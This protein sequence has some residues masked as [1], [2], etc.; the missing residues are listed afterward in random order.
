M[1][2]SRLARAPK[3]YAELLSS[4]EQEVEDI[5][6]TGDSNRLNIFGR[7]HEFQDGS[8]RVAPPDASPG[9]FDYETSTEAHLDPSN[10]A[11]VRLCPPT[12][13]QIGQKKLLISEQANKC[14]KL[15]A[16]Y[17]AQ[18]NILLQIEKQLETEERRLL[19]N[20]ASIAPIGHVPQE[21]LSMI[22]YIHVIEHR[23]LPWVL[24]R[25]CRMWRFTALATPALWSRIKLVFPVK[26]HEHIGIP[27]GIS[28][29]YEVCSQPGQI[30]R[31]LRRAGTFPLD[32][33]VDLGD[34]LMA[35]SSLDIGGEVE[36]FIGLL[37]QQLQ[38]PRLRSL[39]IDGPPWANLPT[40]FTAFDFTTLQ[41]LKLSMDQPS[42][43]EKVAKESQNIYAFTGSFKRVPLLKGKLK[44][45]DEL[46]I[47]GAR[48]DEAQ[49][50]AQVLFGISDSLRVLSL[51]KGNFSNTPLVALPNLES[52]VL[53]NV[54]PVWPIECPNITHLTLR[55]E[56]DVQNDNDIYLPNLTH[57]DFWGR[58]AMA[59]STFDA[60]LL[61]T[62]NIQ[63]Y[64]GDK[65][66]MNSGLREIWLKKSKR[67]FDPVVF[68]Y[69]GRVNPK[70]LAKALSRLTKCEEIY[71]HFVE[72]G[73]DFFDEL[74]E[75]ADDNVKKG[76]KSRSMSSRSVPLPNLRKLVG[77]MEDCGKEFEE[78]ELRES[79]NAFVEW[80]KEAGVPME[81]LSL[82][83]EGL[84]WKDF[85]KVDL[86]DNGM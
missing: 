70:V 21:V 16:E 9:T 28:D 44:H 71:S 43:I 8:S 3:S 7:N 30:V 34:R 46:V 54:S 27:S 6:T 83:Y 20:K 41:A 33:W 51:P 62:L 26:G 12:A 82:H 53:K 31:A 67:R 80:R 77:D 22:F 13:A 60:P 74:L 18:K 25:I 38:R 58:S 42:I 47:N 63:V 23:Q 5:K 48:N 84:R 59:L 56:N 86:N 75:C 29:G 50:V 36:P 55:P 52:L 32:L 4:S 11:A 24:M 64:I 10:F 81:E 66:E 72:L 15:K 69:W 78:T 1:S 39:R 76:R 68:K 2:R 14:A 65:A 57:L 19:E 35:R 40:A 79:V 73:P 85:L 49:E 17:E 61:H 37:T 45:A